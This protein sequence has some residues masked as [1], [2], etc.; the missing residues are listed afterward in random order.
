MACR[1]TDT[2]FA[3]TFSRRAQS[4]VIE[5]MTAFSFDLRGSRRHFRTTPASLKTAYEKWPPEAISQQVA[6]GG[7]D[8][9]QIYTKSELRRPFPNRWPREVPT[10]YKSIRK[11]N[12]GSHFPAGVPER[13]RQRT[14]L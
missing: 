10:A 13:S 12:S 1:S 9:A 6:Q 2:Y 7:L 3:L 5:M 4:M 11:V 14:N 8:S